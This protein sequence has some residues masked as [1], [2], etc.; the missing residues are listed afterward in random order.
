MKIIDR[1]MDALNLYDEEEVFDDEIEVKKPLAK[2]ENSK[3]RISLF[4]PKNIDNSAKE[5]V[6]KDE[7]EVRKN[8]NRK[9]LLSF[10]SPSTTESENNKMS[11]KTI[12]LPVENKLVSVVILKPIS[13]NEDAPKIADCLKNNQPI[14]VNFN[15]TDNAV[16]KHMTDF[17]SGAV[18]AIGGNMKK[19]GRN[20]LV[21]APKNVDIDAGIDLADNKED[22]FWK[23]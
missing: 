22:Q 8:S 4:R 20:I 7:K 5:D 14:V 15:D 23:K 18:Y 1:I 3:E 16:A 13:F 10:K 12:K 19:I 2:E 11:S 9:S 21:C 17:I 6:V